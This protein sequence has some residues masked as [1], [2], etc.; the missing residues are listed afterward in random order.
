VRGLLGPVERKNSWQ[1]AEHVGAST[2]HGFQR[3]LGRAS[4]DAD[5]PRDE[6]RRYASEH[7]LAPG[8]K[9]EADWFGFGVADGVKGPRVYDWAA[10]CYGT[11]IEHQR[12]ELAPT[13]RHRAHAGVVPLAPTP[14]SHRPPLPPSRKSTGCGCATVVLLVIDNMP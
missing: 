1:L 6:V 11:P 2:P 5:I 13:E 3:L 9:G 7:L 12:G 14:P 8:N 4:W 10:G